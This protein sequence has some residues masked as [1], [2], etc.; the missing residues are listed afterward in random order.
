MLRLTSMISLWSSRS[1]ASMVSLLASL[2]VAGSLACGGDTFTPQPLIDQSA[3]YWRLDL[4]H[5]AILLSTAAPHDTL[6]LTATPRNYRGDA[7]SG[8]PMPTFASQNLT[9][10][11]VTP[12][13]VLR[14]IAPTT[15]GTVVAVVARLTIDDLTHVDT[16]F[17]SVVSTDPPPTLASFSIH[18]IPPDSAK[19]GAI[20]AVLFSSATSTRL[21][22]TL[23]I[24]ATDAA[25][26]P[27]LTIPGHI[28]GILPV[29]LRSSDTAV[30]QFDEKIFTTN[31]MAELRGYQVGTATISASTTAFGV[32]MVDTLDYR[33][34]WALM[35]TILMVAPSDYNTSAPHVL[36]INNV[37][38]YPLLRI[39]VGGVV[40]WS[41]VG[42]GG[43]TNSTPNHILFDDDDLPNVLSVPS[44]PP[45]MPA[46]V[47]N[48]SCLA[49][50]GADCVNGGNMVISQTNK[51]ATRQFLVPG[52]YDYSS[53]LYPGSV[54][55]IVVIDEQ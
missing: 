9:N 26:M 47:Y 2:A 38:T 3:L 10:V 18:P 53:S 17:I 55:K 8:A 40:T 42:I 51:K 31:K 5:R 49:F 48:S 41:N 15:P 28:S 34:G 23:S 30:V 24:R 45:F 44:R 27:I 7:L 20:P 37:F 12:E 1:Y 6:R 29:A 43:D 35:A 13:G 16:A 54:G 21:S 39:G 32:R 14:A 46:I 36:P 19:V 4:D 52:V 25:G 22:D 11:I 33:V 50:Y